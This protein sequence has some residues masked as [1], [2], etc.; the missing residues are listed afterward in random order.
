MSSAPFYPLS[1]VPQLLL[2][3]LLLSFVESAS[4]GVID[5]DLPLS[6]TEKRDELT[7]ALCAG[8]PDTWVL[9]AASRLALEETNAAAEITTENIVED[10][11]RVVGLPK[12]E[13]RIPLDELP[14]VLMVHGLEDIIEGSYPQPVVRYLLSRPALDLAKHS[15]KAL[16]NPPEPIDETRVAHLYLSRDHP[17][18]TGHSAAVWRAELELPGQGELGAGQR[19]TVAAKIA[20]GSFVADQHLRNEARMY[21]LFPEHLSQEWAGFVVIPPVYYP[22][23]VGPVVP[24]FYGLYQPEQRL[25][26]PSPD[27]EGDEPRLLMLIEECGKPIEKTNLSSSA[28]KVSWSLLRRLH[29]AGFLQ[30]SFYER[31]VVVQPGP[32]C[33]PPDQRTMD[34]PSYRIIDFGRGRTTRDYP[35]S[36]DKLDPIPNGMLDQARRIEGEQQAEEALGLG[37]H[38][39]MGSV[40]IGGKEARTFEVYQIPL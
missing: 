14:H 21:S 24:H 32:L 30:G 18:G 35:P 5:S 31:N 1:P 7:K 10:I 17:L 23:P 40:R 15:R 22:V 37:M 27:A 34:N 39:A 9:Q 28:K 26:Y 11:P 12:L 29:I 4:S 19:F 16:S 36:F 13:E 8:F 3:A 25:A 2:H 20:D 38:A 33:L 6:W